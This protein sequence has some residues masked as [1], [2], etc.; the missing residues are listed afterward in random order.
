MGPKVLVVFVC[1]IVGFSALFFWIHGLRRRI[2]A[3]E[4]V[5]GAEAYPDGPTQEGVAT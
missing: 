3:L 2:L 1:S 5:S 4:E